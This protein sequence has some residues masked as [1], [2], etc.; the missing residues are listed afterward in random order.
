VLKTQEQVVFTKDTESIFQ[1]ILTNESPFKLFWEKANKEPF[2]IKSDHLSA[3][4]KLIEKANRANQ[5]TRNAAQKLQQI[6]DNRSIMKA[7]SPDFFNN[8]PEPPPLSPQKQIQAPPKIQ[9][10]KIPPQT[11]NLSHIELMKN[12]S[13]IAESLGYDKNIG[14]YNKAEKFAKD[15]HLPSVPIYN[16]WQSLKSKAENLG[17]KK[18][19]MIDVDSYHAATEWAKSHNKDIP[20]ASRWN[21]HPDNPK[22][23]QASVQPGNDKDPLLLE[24]LTA[25]FMKKGQQS[26]ETDSDPQNDNDTSS[27]D[28]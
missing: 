28:W 16:E 19:A 1:K 9:P 27:D 7:S 3:I 18:G 26:G 10:P 12:Q 5:T 11:Q 2:G 24:S 14:V 8:L 17:Y 25:Q 6:L 15:Y 23:V 20:D 13:T 21:E 22:R 4:L